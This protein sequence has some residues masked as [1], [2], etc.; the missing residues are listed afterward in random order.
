MCRVGRKLHQGFIDERL[1]DRLAIAGRGTVPYHDAQVGIVPLG[2]KRL[3][4]V[5][6]RAFEIGPVFD[7]VALEA[8]HGCTV[9]AHFSGKLFLRRVRGGQ[10]FHN[11]CHDILGKRLGRSVGELRQ[12]SQ[13][14]E[15]KR[16]KKHNHLVSVGVEGVEEREAERS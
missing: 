12:E 11:F 15:S 6:V 4:D 3:L 8:V 16:T 10:V 2:G 9:K 5:A 13:T 14:K 1:F 7:D